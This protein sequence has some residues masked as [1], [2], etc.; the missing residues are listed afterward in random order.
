MA[1]TGDLFKLVFFRV[2]SLVNKLVDNPLTSIILIFLL[3]TLFLSKSFA[4]Q[5][6]IRKVVE[7]FKS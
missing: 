3:G 7:Y 4:Q 5:F 6:T 1:K 2:P